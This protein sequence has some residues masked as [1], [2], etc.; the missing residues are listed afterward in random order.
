MSF[1]L[2]ENEK[3]ISGYEGIYSVDKTG[4]IYSYYK[5]T[6]NRLVGGV[7]FDKSRNSTTYRM[8]CLSVGG[9]SKSVYC[10]RM[11]AEAFL[12]NPE[13]K[14]E[15]NHIDG[16]KLNN[17]LEN[18]EWSTRSENTQ[19]AY[20]TGLMDNALVSDAQWLDRI[21]TF[22]TTGFSG[23]QPTHV[24]ARI[25]AH[26]LYSHHIPREFIS[27]SKSHKTEHSPLTVWNHYIDL[28]RL[29]DSELSL[30][31][32]AKVVGMDPSMISYLRSGK[33]GKRAR[34]VYDKYKD[35][36]YYFVNYKPVYKYYI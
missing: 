32:V 23:V 2:A 36:P 7:I 28:F 31:Q 34:K 25:T 13:N 21:N 29:C 35:D 18:L 22:I 33:R 1:V 5:G 19:H 6:K 15:V 16:D 12:P 30:S 14:K 27:V 4:E 20:D 11:V 26:H 24:K 17:R 9:C 3:W 10:H 8:M